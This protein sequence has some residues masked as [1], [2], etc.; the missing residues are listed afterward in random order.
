[1]G[2]EAR[3]PLGKDGR[4]IDQFEQATSKRNGGIISLL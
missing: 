3:K 4:L 2:F 1:M